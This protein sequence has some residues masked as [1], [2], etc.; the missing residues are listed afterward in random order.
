M[1]KNVLTILL[2]AAIALVAFQSCED[3]ENETKISSYNS[4]ES[5]K[6][7]QNC[8]ICHVS[9]GDGEGWF[10]VAGTVYESELTSVL[11]NATVKLYTEANGAGDLIATVEVDGKGNFYTTKVIDFGTGLYTLVEG[12]TTT[13]NMYSKI[14]SGKCNSCHGVSIDRIWT[15]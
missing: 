13:K 2:G 9:G 8:M 4:D 10:T 7:G 15:E 1:K 14:T 11:P 5:H 6:A 12:N 3:E